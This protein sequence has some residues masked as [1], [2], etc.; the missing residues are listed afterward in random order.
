[1]KML[2]LNEMYKTIFLS[3]AT[4]GTIDFITEDNKQILNFS[5]YEEHAPLMDLSMYYERMIQLEEKELIDNACDE[6]AKYIALRFKDKRNN[7][8]NALQ[9]EYNPLENYNM[10]QEETPNI[11]KS[12]ETKIDVKTD[13]ET[14]NYVSGFNSSVPQHATKGTSTGDSLTTGAKEDNVET[15]TGN[16]KLTRSGN[17]GVT[18]SQQMLESE[19]KLREYDFYQVVF[20]DIDKILCS[21]SF[22]L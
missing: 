13:T 6:I 11:T 4:L 18:T 19:L 22:N 12:R 14:N 2:M 3:L 7:I 9:E 15:E 16:R 21:R 20:S 17:I 10:I 5:Y 8:Y 1:M